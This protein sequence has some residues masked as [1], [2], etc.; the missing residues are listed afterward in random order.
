MDQNVSPSID[1]LRTSEPSRSMA[2]LMSARVRLD[3][4]LRSCTVA[5]PWLVR[6]RRGSATHPPPPPHRRG[7]G[8]PSSRRGEG[9]CFPARPPPPIAPARP[10]RLLR[11]RKRSR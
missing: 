4:H 5:G 1:S 10:P 7:A 8:T 3:H 2:L 9:W 11:D 6:Y